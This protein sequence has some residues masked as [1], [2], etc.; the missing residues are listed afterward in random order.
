MKRFKPEPR[1]VRFVVS[2]ISAAAIYCLLAFF[3]VEQ[4]GWQ[5]LTAG[6]V[7]YLSALPVAY[8]LHRMF[9]FRSR[10]QIPAEASRFVA[11]SLIGIGLSSGLL[12]TMTK[13]GMP[14]AGALL[15]TCVLIPAANYLAMSRWT[16]TGS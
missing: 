12:T 16:F 1:L 2:G 15:V 10:S 8:L 11:T 6:L 14:L 9:T 3:A 5:P 13:L 7:A 4:L